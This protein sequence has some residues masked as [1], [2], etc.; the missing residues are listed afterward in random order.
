MA[1]KE[2]SDREIA[3]LLA[4]LRE[5]TASSAPSNPEP[6]S[7]K[8]KNMSDDD[9]KALLRRYYSDIDTLPQEK[10]PA[11]EFDTSDFEPD[12]SPNVEEKVEKPKK[13]RP[14]RKK[15]EPKPSTE[16]I[17]PEPIEEIAVEVEPEP[18]A[19]EETF[20]ESEPEAI[21]PQVEDEL[22][23]SDDIVAV[24]LEEAAE[25]IVEENI[26]DENIVDTPAVEVE[27]TEDEE[28]VDEI[29]YDLTDLASD[30]TNPLFALDDNEP[31]SAPTEPEKPEESEEPEVI[32]VTEAPEPLEAESDEALEADADIDELEL[33]DHPVLPDE[34]DS[35]EWH[36]S[37]DV[38]G[39]SDDSELDMMVALG[40]GDK[41]VE[42]YGDER[43]RRAT[44]K[45]RL[46][47]ERE[48]LEINA[49]GY[50]GTELTKHSDIAK[51]SA[52]YVKLQKWLT[53][54]LIGSSLLVAILF[55]V[56]NLKFL[57]ISL[58]GA[59]DSTTL[60]VLI[61]A[62]L[63]VGVAAISYKKL[64]EAILFAFGHR[65][66]GN[67]ILPITL[68]IMLGYDL[69][70]ILS[71][72]ESSVALFNFPIALGFVFELLAELFDLVR[73]RRIF[74]LLFDSDV[75][76]LCGLTA[77]GND[78]RDR[79][80]FSADRISFVEGYFRRSSDN[81]RSCS[82]QMLLTVLPLA[83]GGALLIIS[84]SVVG[85]DSV[86]A[87]SAFPAVFAFAA[88]L[89]IIFNHAWQQLR[90]AFALADKNAGVIGGVA[91]DEYINAKCV[92]FDDKLAFPQD[93]VE[94]RSIKLYDN[95]EIYNTIY[96]VN[97]LFQKAGG[98]LRE[99]MQYT[100]ANLG[101]PK[102][103]IMTAAGDHYVEALVDKKN[104]VCAGSYTALTSRGI[105]VE[106]N[107][108]DSRD[109]EEACVMYAAINGEVCARFCVRY[110]LD[111]SF[112]GA[113]KLLASDGIGI[114]LR[115]LDPNLDRA[116]LVAQFG[117]HIDAGVRREPVRTHFDEPSGTSVVA[118][119]DRLGL[120]EPL[121]VGRRLSRAEHKLAVAGVLQLMVGVVVA[122]L[123]LF[124]DVP[125]YMFSAL[126]SVIQLLGVL[127]AALI[128]SLNVKR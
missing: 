123:V 88:P 99:L 125:S 55:F 116:M 119:G 124:F 81:R 113:A 51:L 42:K 45:L 40:L 111:E 32:E 90:A 100:A 78:D 56:E 103:V 13:P 120:A 63:L 96:N 84:S 86:R 95:S 7:K 22:E 61:A 19:V 72:T 28:D 117:E 66:R 49:H 91:T 54:K 8:A 30:N 87:I 80:L 73:E 16:S 41:L 57:G 127:P 70:I 74:A 97:A 58:G 64:V 65:R 126:S 1:K 34:E 27:E 14:E 39:R 107:P 92:V 11:F 29:L 48:Q 47:E 79:Y 18:E 38:S 35:R 104:T 25:A 20:V 37:H 23:S 118:R 108:D 6:V 31:E 109:S 5:Q 59:L 121:V 85:I 77:L 98:P 83:A 112:L 46:R 71:F 9:V 36:P 67:V 101:E 114:R 52:R 110:H 4:E 50:N 105:A 24:T 10:E 76:K 62:L 82:T 93:K 21:Q 60:R 3:E 122:T 115:T 15:P 44:E 75:G 106:R 2:Q 17:E 33:V 94:I 53:I 26:T 89:A 68:L 102:S 128:Y 69:V 12:E 43:V